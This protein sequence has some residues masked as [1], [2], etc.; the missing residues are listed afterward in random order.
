MVNDKSMDV[1]VV[2]QVLNE[3]PLVVVGL[4][5]ITEFLDSMVLLPLWPP[6]PACECFIDMLV[7]VGILLGHKTEISMMLVMRQQ[8]SHHPFKYY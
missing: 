6:P 1:N 4:D 8:P 2:L 5:K 3:V 7:D